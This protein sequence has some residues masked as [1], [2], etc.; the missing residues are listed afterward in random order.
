MKR[1]FLFFIFTYIFLCSILAFAKENPKPGPVSVK[2]EV[3]KPLAAIGDKIK[4]SIIVKT[5]NDIEI[6]FPGSGENLGGLAV[7]DKGVLKK[8]FFSNKTLT[9]W[10]L[11]ET[12]ITGD[13]TIP[14]VV[15]KYKEKN[16]DWQEIEAGEIKIKVKSVLEE[17]PEAKDIRDIKEPVSLRSKI[18]TYIILMLIF[19]FLSSVIVYGILVIRKKHLKILASMVKSSHQ[20]AYERFDQLRKKNLLAAG[21]I[22]EYYIE[23][24]GIIRRY[25][26]DRFRLRAP[27]MT[28]EEFLSSVTNSKELTYEHRALLSD[29]LFRCDLVKFAKYGPSEKEINLSFESAVRLIDQTKQDEKKEKS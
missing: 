8:R 25:L 7:R 29:F 18:V 5:K 21:K 3:E 4:Y 27:E 14:K 23:L 17:T 16:K 20:L 11:L 6:E 9:Q 12:Y 15:I 22:K 24:S 2:A 10:Y 28:T 19:I 1:G 13:Y 26:E